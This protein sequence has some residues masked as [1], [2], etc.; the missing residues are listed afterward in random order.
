MDYLIEAAKPFVVGQPEA[1]ISISRKFDGLTLMN[2]AVT[3]SQFLALVDALQRAEAE[4]P[5]RGVGEGS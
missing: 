2:V 1:A 4:T 3:K 5:R